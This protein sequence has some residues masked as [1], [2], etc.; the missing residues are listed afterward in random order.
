[1]S[2]LLV[3]LFG[4]CS[5]FVGSESGQEQSAKLLQSMVYNTTQH[6]PPPTATHCLDILYVDFGKGGDGWGG[7]GEG[8]REGG[9]ATVHK[10]GRK[11][12]HD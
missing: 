4:W 6:P 10:R 7:G 9:G 8:Q 2:S 5:Y 1:M 12:Q 3:F 11:Y